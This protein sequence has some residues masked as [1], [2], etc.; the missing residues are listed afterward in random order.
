MSITFNPAIT[1]FERSELVRAVNLTLSNSRVFV[2]VTYERD[3]TRRPKDNYIAIPITPSDPTLHFGWMRRPKYSPKGAMLLPLDDFARADGTRASAIRMLKPER[4]TAFQVR[5]Y[6]P[7]VYFSTP[8]QSPGGISTHMLR[9]SL[10]S[11][12]RVKPGKIKSNLVA[13]K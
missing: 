7:D 4:I 8:N 6:E 9:P 10:D 3:S 12:T 5:G 1:P 11:G 13:P 2:W